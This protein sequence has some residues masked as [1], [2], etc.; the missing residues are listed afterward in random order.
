MLGR[1]RVIGAGQ[2]L[3]GLLTHPGD[4]WQARWRAA[5]ADRGK[6]WIEQL[7]AR[8]DNGHSYQGRRS[9]LLSG[10]NSMFIS[11]VVLPD[12]EFLRGYKAMAPFKD[13]QHMFR[14]GTPEQM[15]RH[16]SGPGMTGRHLDEG[17]RVLSKMILHTG[18]DPDQLTAEDAFEAGLGTAGHRLLLR[19]HPQRLGSA[20]RRRGDPLQGHP[21]GRAAAQPA[22]HRRTGRLPQPSVHARAQPAGPLPRRT[23]SRCRLRHLRRPGPSTR[24]ARW[25]SAAPATTS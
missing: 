13:V 21:Q 2:V 8:T 6:D 17:L 12:Y 14:A 1:N 15:R 24:A 22:P 20:P 23:P 16:G 9:A 11:R 19:R 4:G 10:L 25:W 7:L 18:R 3:D 5:D